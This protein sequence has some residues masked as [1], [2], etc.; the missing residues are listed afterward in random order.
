MAN[1]APGF[2]KYPDYRIELQALEGRVDIVVADE[3]VCSTTKA[4]WLLETRHARALYVPLADCRQLA[5]SDM[6]TYC[7]F[8]GEA[9]YFSVLRD[10]AGPDAVESGRDVFWH[11]AEPFDE[12]LRIADLLGVY[13]DRV[14]AIRV[15][16]VA[17]AP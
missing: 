14:D 5:A 17:L 9:S 7:P 2:L 15:D 3:V 16:G 13:S 8:K 6:R 10:G 4:T 1:P 11:Y 12:V